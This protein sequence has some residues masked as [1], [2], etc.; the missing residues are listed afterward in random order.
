MDELE[1][2]LM[3]NAEL[4]N[5]PEDPTDVREE[6][7]EEIEEEVVDDEP[8]DEEPS[9]EEAPSPADDFPKSWKQDVK[10]HWASLPPEIKA[11]VLRREQDIF[12]GIE[13]Y[14]AAAER[15]KAFDDVLAPHR[16]VMEQHGVDPILLVRDL[17]SAHRV[18]SLGSP[19]QKAQAFEYLFKQ[20]GFDPRTSQPAAQPAAADDLTSRLAAI[21][22]RLEAGSRANAE[23]RFREVSQTVA[24]FARDKPDFEAVAGDVARLLRADKQLSLDEAYNQARRLN[25]QTFE[26]ILATEREK[27]RKEAE[28]QAA[29][30]RRAGA[31]NVRS[32]D[33]EASPTGATGSMEETMQRIFDSMS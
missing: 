10:A 5:I 24:D 21:E 20:Y 22:S 32:R 19:E 12:K 15:A 33:S 28:E 31:V 9:G 7:D 23:A 29:K 6:V 17:A 26:T 27:A 3:M 13:G 2:T 18:L 4:M 11:E 14:K 30:A 16:E 1:E 25:P 8:S